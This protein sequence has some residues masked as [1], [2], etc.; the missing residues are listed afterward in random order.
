MATFPEMRF[1]FSITTATK[2]KVNFVSLFLLYV[3]LCSAFAFRRF[4]QPTS[5]V[6]SLIAHHEGA[7]FQYNLVKFDGE[8]LLL[9]A[10]ES[11]FF[12]RI[13][14][15]TGYVLNIPYGT[16]SSRNVSL[17]SLTNVHVDTKTGLLSSTK[18]A[19]AS[20]THFGISHSLLSY[21][22][23]T[24]FLACPDMSYRGQYRVFWKGQN[25]TSC[26]RNATGYDITLLVQIDATINYDIKT[27]TD[28]FPRA[29][30][31]VTKREATVLY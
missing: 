14:A 9:N 26:P 19:N 4:Y 7:V 28:V 10:D 6:F 15:S 16:N 29:Y 22:N 1:D 18:A 2:M 5:P 31:P 3:C 11:A 13:R 30:V 27:N 8:D 21:K 12:G 23:S 20:L 17:P 24:S 25:I